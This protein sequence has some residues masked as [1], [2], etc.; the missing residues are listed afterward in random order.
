MLYYRCRCGECAAYGSMPP[1][2]C[3]GCVEC[4]TNLAAHPSLNKAPE[5]HDFVT[6]HV[7]TDDGLKPFSHCRYCFRTRK[8]AAYV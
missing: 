8:D 4:G 7:Q 1:A 2:R 3:T 6:S 5:P